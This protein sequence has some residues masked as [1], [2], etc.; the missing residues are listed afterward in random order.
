MGKYD[1]SEE[2]SP[3]NAANPMGSGVA[4][5]ADGRVEDFFSQGATFSDTSLWFLRPN[6]VM[7]AMFPKVQVK[8]LHFTLEAVCTKLCIK[9]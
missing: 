6:V 8:A 3:S 9:P 5:V 2:R 1:E 7:H 4:A